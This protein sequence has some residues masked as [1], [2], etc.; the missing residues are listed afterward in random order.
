MVHCI[1]R[2]F[3]CYNF[4]NKIVYR[5]LKII[6]VLENRVDPDEAFH[7]IPVFTVCQSTHLGVAN[8]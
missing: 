3:T 4:Q 6:F 7:L 1:M 5:S 8:I 2:G